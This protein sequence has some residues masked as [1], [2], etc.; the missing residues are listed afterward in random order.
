MKTSIICTAFCAAM[1][2]FSH[3][4]H[5][6]AL[7][8]GDSHDL[9]SVLNG[10]SSGDSDRLTYVNHLLGMALGTSGQANGQKYSRS[11]SD[12]GPLTQGGLLGLVNGAGITIDLG[13]GVY[14]YLFVTY[15][16][17]NNGSEAWYVGDLSGSITIPAQAK[18]YALSG[19]TLSSTA[20]SIPDGGAT[21]ILLGAALM[22]LGVV[23]RHLKS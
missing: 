7:T 13:S 18:G 17:P 8:I 1:L 15:N 10:W 12:F 6:L 2:A 22:A 16:A 11:N 21:M 20:E 9:G 14:S 3:D 4:A 19:W 23:R 5:A